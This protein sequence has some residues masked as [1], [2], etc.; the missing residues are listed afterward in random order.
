V[1]KKHLYYGGIVHP[2][3]RVRFIGQREVIADKLGGEVG[4]F[5]TE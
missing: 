5:I 2:H 4:H 3:P 1:R